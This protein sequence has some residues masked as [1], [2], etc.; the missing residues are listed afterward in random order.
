MCYLIDMAEKGEEIL[1]EEVTSW[2]T[3][4]PTDRLIDELAVSFPT[5]FPKHLTSKITREEYDIMT[6]CKHYFH[7]L[8]IPQ[9]RHMELNGKPSPQEAD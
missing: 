6:L 9:F 2:V 1:M 8:L 3:K 5:T 4:D 7:F